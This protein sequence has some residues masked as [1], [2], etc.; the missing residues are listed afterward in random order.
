MRE[1][2]IYLLV[3]MILT[4]PATAL[5]QAEIIEVFCPTCGFRKRFI[6][7]ADTLDQA[8]NLQHLIV[9]CE[10]AGLIRNI[11]IPLDPNAP[12]GREPLLARHQGTGT[13]RLLG[14]ELPKFL[15]PGNTCP[16]FPLAAYL[17][18]NICP[19]D[20]QPGIEYAVVGQY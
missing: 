4:L 17:E 15:V 1:K 13:S 16:L 10:R 8:K 9:V 2:T 20:G 7:G 11:T 18:A 3:L 6:Q 5:A 19:V 14:I 12:V